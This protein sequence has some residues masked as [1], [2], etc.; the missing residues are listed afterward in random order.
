MAIDYLSKKSQPEGWQYDTN[1]LEGELLLRF[2]LY[3]KRMQ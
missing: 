1:K 3:T 2:K